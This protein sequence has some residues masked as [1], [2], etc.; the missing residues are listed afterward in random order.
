MAGSHG[1]AVLKQ[2]SR[3]R[4]QNE[5]WLDY[6]QSGPNSL[7]YQQIFI[8]PLAKNVEDGWKMVYSWLS[9][10]VIAPGVLFV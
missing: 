6:S 7:A 2:E 8:I 9:S 3:G 10:L 4:E 1:W 5:P